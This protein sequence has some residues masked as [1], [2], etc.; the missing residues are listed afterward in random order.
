MNRLACYGL[1]LLLAG[2]DVPYVSRHRPTTA[3]QPEFAP[4]D[5]VP[6]LPELPREQEKAKPEGKTPKAERLQARS[7]LEIIRYVMGEFARVVRPL[8]AHKKGYRMRVGQPVNDEELRKFAAVGGFAAGPG[9]NVQITQLYFRNQEIVVEINGGGKKK[10]N[11]RDRIQIGVTGMPRVQ[12]SGA[13]AP[14]YQGVGATLILDFGRPLPEMT[15]DEVKQH[16]GAFLDFS[17][18]RSAAVQWV[19]TLP[20]EFQQA[21]KERRAMVGMDRETV[22]AALGKPERKIRERDDDGLETEDWI[23]G[24][25][26]A[27]TVFVKFAGDRVISVKEFPR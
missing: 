19:E 3:P 24:Q 16:L 21:I 4:G 5:S 7:R 8:P 13:A 23:Y 10:T 15:A 11:W 2:L 6:V 20:P 14:G 18:Q 26:P 17:R 1:V 25:P 12:T 22:I 9:D 27:R